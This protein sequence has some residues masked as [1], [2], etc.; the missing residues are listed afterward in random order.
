MQGFFC[1]FSVFYFNVGHHLPVQSG[2]SSPSHIPFSLAYVPNQP[3]TPQS[4]SPAALQPTIAKRQQQQLPVRPP[5]PCPGA[6]T[7]TGREEGSGSPG[8]GWSPLKTLARGC[9]TRE[10]P[11]SGFPALISHCRA[12]GRPLP[13]RAL[14]A[15]RLT[16]QAEAR[17]RRPG[18]RTAGFPGLRGGGGCGRK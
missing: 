6:L 18:P 3:P 14:I 7:R 11:P 13:R 4:A 15:H 10:P 12:P 9:R 2:A 16:P 8:G 17:A 5:P 1:L